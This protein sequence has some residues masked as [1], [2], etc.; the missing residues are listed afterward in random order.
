MANIASL[1]VSMTAKTGPFKK[2]LKRAGA[3]L[4]KF[5][6][7]MKSVRVGLI[8]LGAGLA[9]A[10]GGGALVKLFNRFRQDIDQTAKFAA[11]MNT[12]IGVVRGFEIAASRAGI[13]QEEFRK[14]FSRSLRAI[15]QGTKAGGALS[16]ATRAFDAL[17]LDAEQLS[18]MGAEDQFLTI[19]DA[20]GKMEDKTL[21]TEV[22]ASIFGRTWAKFLKLA[23]EGT[24]ELEKGLTAARASGQF[25]SQDQAA[26]VQRL[27]DLLD[28]LK[29]FF[30]GFG[31]QITATLSGPLAQFAESIKQ[32]FIEI[33]KSPGGIANVA[34]NF[35]TSI[36]TSFE[37][38]VLAMATVINKISE[39]AQKMEQFLTDPMSTLFGGGAGG[40]IKPA[41]DIPALRS[42]FQQA[43]EN[44]AD[45]Q[46]GV[47]REKLG[48]LPTGSGAFVN[49]VEVMRNGEK[50]LGELKTQT[51]QLQQW[52]DGIDKLEKQRP[53]LSFK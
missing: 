36:I 28:D 42:G 7:R 35:A 34:I 18:K 41:I 50:V 44:V 6:K 19:I 48:Q 46:A 12:T 38:V 24:G 1:A 45:Q 23:D 40:V 21:R 20:L 37:Q 47:V 13:G 22:A 39:V 11:A 15:A 30:D 14:G 10:L 53:I 2:G 31:Q 4:A 5:R 3:L 8:G 49:G 43:L 33:A 17:G 29:R 25:L 27:N 16:T 52:L 32:K 51:S 26:G 9:A